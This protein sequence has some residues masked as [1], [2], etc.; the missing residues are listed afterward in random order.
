MLEIVEN[1]FHIP[2]AGVNGEFSEAAKTLQTKFFR[3]FH[4]PFR[5]KVKAGQRQEAVGESCSGV[6]HVVIVTLEQTGGSP[7]E[8]EYHRA[9][10]SAIVHRLDKG[11]RRRHFRIGGA[12]QKLEFRF[13]SKEQVTLVSDIGRENV[14]VNVYNQG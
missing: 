6:Q 8:A 4:T 3:L 14:R 10:Y 2:A 11:F 12:V 5:E 9:V 1:T 7:G 13:V